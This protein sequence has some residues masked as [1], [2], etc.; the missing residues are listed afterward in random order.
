MARRRSTCHACCRPLSTLNACIGAASLRRD[1]ASSLFRPLPW[2]FV[3]RHTLYT[4]AAT[5]IMATEEAVK[6]HK[7]AKK[8]DAVKDA[9]VKKEKKEKKKRKA[10]DAA[11]RGPCPGAWAFLLCGKEVGSL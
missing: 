5:H 6:A 2:A 7:K 9:A 8:G 1:P 4:D 3:D 10:E 11:V